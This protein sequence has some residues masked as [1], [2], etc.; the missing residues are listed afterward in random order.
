[1]AVNAMWVA[2]MLGIFGARFR[3]IPPVVSA[4][5]QVIVFVTPIFWN[6]DQIKGRVGLVLT[7][8]N[9]FYHFVQIVRA[10]LLGQSPSSVSWL[11]AIVLAVVGWL[12]ML[13]MFS[14]FHR[15]IAYWL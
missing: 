10:P 2:I 5:L 15:R 1:V 6:A 4:V 7:D 9:V 3:D 8:L 14:R 13:A 12:L 11:V